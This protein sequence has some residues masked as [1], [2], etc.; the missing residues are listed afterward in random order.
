MFN[1]V[2]GQTDVDKLINSFFK[3]ID[4]DGLSEKPSKKEGK[5]EYVLEV[6][7]PGVKKDSI[8]VEVL[9]EGVDVSWLDKSG[10]ARQYKTQRVVGYDLDKLTAKYEDGLLTL[11]APK[12]SK[13][14]G[15]SVVIE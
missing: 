2:Y 12:V 7:L 9:F 15:K 4:E 10:T 8:K 3:L 14:V 6:E 13:S 5:P 1:A 11:R